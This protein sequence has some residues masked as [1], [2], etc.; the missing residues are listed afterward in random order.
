MNKKIKQI[1]RVMR[2]LLQIVFIALPVIL[3]YAWWYKPLGLHIPPSLSG[4]SSFIISFIPKGLAIMHPLTVMDK[5]YGFL[6]CL[7]PLG[8]ML[9]ILFFMIKLF[10]LYAQGR[11]FSIA[12]VQCLKLSAITLL[13]W[14]FILQPIYQILLSATL[15]WHN[16]PGHRVAT[17]TLSG[18]DMLL[19][20]SA[21]LVWLI[22][23]IMAEGVK[24]LEE[25]TRFV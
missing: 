24:I 18:I 17:L 3:A 20:F 4:H 7:L 1:S 8:V 10:G 25:N 11:I 13:I 14:E 2:L 5:V 12:N 15:T 9:T 19:V 16:P 22:A 6:I 21:I 23:W